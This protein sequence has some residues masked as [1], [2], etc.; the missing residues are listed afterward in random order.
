MRVT[1]YIISFQHINVNIGAID[2]ITH[3]HK[4]EID[5]TRLQSDFMIIF[6]NY[7]IA[8]VQNCS[9][10]VLSF[11]KYG[12]ERESRKSEKWVMI[13]QYVHEFDRYIII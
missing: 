13:I 11:K 7:T 4:R 10:K 5:P 9:S 12:G 2:V 3:T 8:R 1:H 6:M